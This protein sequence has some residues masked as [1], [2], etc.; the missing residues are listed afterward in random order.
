[1]RPFPHTVMFTLCIL[2]CR[3]LELQGLLL[4]Q[5]HFSVPARAA[6]KLYERFDRNH[7]HSSEGCDLLFAGLC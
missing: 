3:S 5:C 7:V 1:M 2:G 4:C 6:V